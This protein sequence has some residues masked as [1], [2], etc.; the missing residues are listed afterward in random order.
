MFT[1]KPYPGYGFI[2]TNKENQ[3][4]YKNILYN[5]VRSDF[6]ALSLSPS[7]DEAMARV[8]RLFALNQRSTNAYSKASVIRK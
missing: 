3:V 7:D 1:L 2:F 4:V 6:N 5:S 8:Q